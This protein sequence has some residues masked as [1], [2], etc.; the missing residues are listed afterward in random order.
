MLL[1]LVFGLPRDP[2]RAE[3][4]GHIDLV[5]IDGHEHASGSVEDRVSAE[6]NSANLLSGIQVNV[7]ETGWPSRMSLSFIRLA[8]RVINQ[9]NLYQEFADFL[10]PACNPNIARSL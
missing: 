2:N 7:D 10:L 1:V 5:L 6:D 4:T 9:T 3:D 8:L